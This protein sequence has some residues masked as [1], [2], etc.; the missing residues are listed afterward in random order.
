MVC[1]FLYVGLFACF[2]VVGEISEL[3]CCLLVGRLVVVGCH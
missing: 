1:F 2:V 3:Y